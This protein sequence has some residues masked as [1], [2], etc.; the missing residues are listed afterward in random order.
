MAEF[1][2]DPQ[3]DGDSLPLVEL[4]LCTVRLM[5]DA[6]FPWLLMVPKRPDLVELTDLAPREQY[7]LMDEIHDI[8][9]ALKSVT[10]CDKLNVAMLGNQVR[11]LHVHVV[12]RFESDAA[13][14]GPIWGKVEPKPY[15]EADASALT[16]KLTAALV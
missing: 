10:G 11:Q 13:W 4:E 7:E 8:S 9:E 16:K 15:G 3:L 1:T 5:N 12:A 2:L 14:P 6:N